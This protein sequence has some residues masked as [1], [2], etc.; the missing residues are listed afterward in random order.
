MT[1]SVPDTVRFPA[2]MAANWT[3]FVLTAAYVLSFIDRQIISLLVEPMRADLEI[4][5]FQIGLLQGLAFAVFYTIMGIPIARLADKYN[6]KSII[7]AGVFFWSLMT[8][9]CGLAKNFTSLFLF[10]MG[11]GV[12]EAALSPAAFSILSDSYPPNRG[13]TGDG[14][15]HIGYHF[16]C[17]ACLCH[18]RSRG[19]SRFDSYCNRPAIDRQNCP[20]AGCLPISRFSGA[21]T[22][23][24]HSVSIG[25][26]A[27]RQA[28]V[29]WR[30]G[31]RYNIPARTYICVGSLG[32]RTVL[33]TL[34]L[35]FLP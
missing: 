33:S 30:I 24:S 5:D 15:L 1:S 6:R 23:S 20:L 11:V 21:D 8:A 10:R 28:G 2:P 17:R 29:H 18:W 4:T 34:V 7:A 32:A 19:G 9:A 16:R 27:P 3:L 31:P 13:R 12:G 22:C 35:A 25:T 26:F 14:G